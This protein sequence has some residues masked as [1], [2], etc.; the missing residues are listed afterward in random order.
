[1]LLHASEP[2]TR[3]N[4]LSFPLL[5]PKLVRKFLPGRRCWKMHE[6]SEREQKFWAFEPRRLVG[7][8]RFLCL[9]EAFISY[10]YAKHFSASTAPRLLFWNR[11]CSFMKY[12]RWVKN[13]LCWIQK[14]TLTCLDN[15]Y[16]NWDELMLHHHHMS[17]SSLM[18]NPFLNSFIFL[19]AFKQPHAKMVLLKLSGLWRLNLLKRSTQ[20]IMFMAEFGARRV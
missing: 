11:T 20:M 1:M 19:N 6:P 12:L 18:D 17:A 9:A 16:V 13:D 8:V 10:P 5:F 15:L 4:E 7:S 3:S 14:Y 2:L